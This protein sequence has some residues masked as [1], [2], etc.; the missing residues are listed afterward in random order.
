MRSLLRS[1]L[2]AA[3]LAVA[4]IA[5]A[6]DIIVGSWNVKRL[7]HGDRQNFTALAEV[8]KRIDLLALQEVMTEEGLKWTPRSRQF[9]PEFKLSVPLHLQLNSAALFYLR[10]PCLTFWGTCP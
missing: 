8:A 10:K 9:S 2:V 5:S 4:G 3:T 6:S 7:G 1:I